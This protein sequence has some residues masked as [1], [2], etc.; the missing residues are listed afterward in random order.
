VELDNQSDTQSAFQGMSLCLCST[1]TL[2]TTMHGQL[3]FQRTTHPSPKTLG[4]LTSAP[5]LPSMP[6]KKRYD[7]PRV[8]YPCMAFL[9]GTQATQLER[10]P[11]G[12]LSLSTLIAECLSLQADCSA[13]GQKMQEAP[14]ADALLTCPRH[15]RSVCARQ[16]GGLSAVAQALRVFPASVQASAV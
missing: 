10:C 2:S 7:R 3:W 13:T 16:P 12:E 15:A 8:F 9:Q 11:V 6:S 14:S 1:A 5:L 4:Q